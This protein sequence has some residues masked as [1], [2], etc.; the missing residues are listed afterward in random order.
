MTRAS[1]RGGGLQIIF[2]I[3][4][5]LMVTAFFGV[6]SYTFYPPPAPEL[7]LEIQEVNRAEQAIRNSKA[8]QD[9]TSQDR[10]EIQ[11]LTDERNALFDATRAARE[12]WGRITSIVLIFLATLTMAISLIRADELPVI[13]NGLLLGGVFSM[14][15]GVGWIVAT[16]T[17][18]ARFFVMTVALAITVSLGYIRFVRRQASAAEPAGSIAAGELADLEQRVQDLEERLDQAATA[19]GMRKDSLDR[20]D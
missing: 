9:L 4:L 13:S 17:S 1:Q 3:F 8:P 10:A 2:S 11:R 14:L 18:M 16:D 12:S 6:G 20:K 15:Y 5:G 7:E 19:L